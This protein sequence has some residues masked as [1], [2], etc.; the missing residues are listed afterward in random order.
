MLISVVV[1]RANSILVGEFRVIE[2]S[3]WV[4]YLMV[5][6]SGCVV[7]Q[8]PYTDKN[9]RALRDQHTIVFIVWGLNVS[10]VANS[11]LLY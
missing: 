1:V 7:M 11:G 3:V 9:H 2:I 5:G 6:I 8:G 4:E 10:F